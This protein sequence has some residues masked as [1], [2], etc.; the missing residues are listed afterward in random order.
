MWHL[1][2]GTTVVEELGKELHP[3][4]LGYRGASEARP[5]D[6]RKDEN[7]S[8]VREHSI[9]MAHKLTNFELNQTEN[10]ARTPCRVRAATRSAA[11]LAVE[12][13]HEGS[14]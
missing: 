8:V 3:G 1:R 7:L 12:S 11:K 6:A 10:R 14:K 5:A 9:S 2:P 4:G 13:G